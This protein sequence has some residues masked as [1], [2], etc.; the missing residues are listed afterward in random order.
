[1]AQDGPGGLRERVAAVAAAPLEPRPALRTS[2]VPAGV[3]ANA[4]R[5]QDDLWR[6]FKEVQNHLGLRLL[7][8]GAPFAPSPPLPRQAI[9]PGDV[10]DL[11]TRVRDE[12]GALARD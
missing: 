4:A 1:M 10:L 11:S 8:P 6:L 3:D 2:R 7:A 12:A 5:R 9:E